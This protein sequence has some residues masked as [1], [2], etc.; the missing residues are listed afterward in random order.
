MLTNLTTGMENNG[1]LS[2]RGE[3][4]SEDHGANE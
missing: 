3:D 1:N 4:S 2:E